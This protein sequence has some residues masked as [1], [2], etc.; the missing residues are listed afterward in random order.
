MGPESSRIRRELIGRRERECGHLRRRCSTVGWLARDHDDGR[1]IVLAFV[2]LPRQL[3]AMDLSRDGG[4]VQQ[5]SQLAEVFSCWGVR[6]EEFRCRVHW[7][8]ERETE[9]D[10]LRYSVQDRE[11]KE[12]AYAVLGSARLWLRGKGELRSRGG[13]RLAVGTGDCWGLGVAELSCSVVVVVVADL[14][15]IGWTGS[16][17]IMQRQMAA[18]AAAAAATGTTETREICRRGSG[19]G[20]GGRGRGAAG[21]RIRAGAGAGGEFRAASAVTM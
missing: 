18:E 2:A 7:D 4:E 10:R 20:G 1:I 14:M 5:P 6:W 15:K 3:P 13:L 16:E 9:Q 8:G 19:G 17:R 21:V 12:L 11:E